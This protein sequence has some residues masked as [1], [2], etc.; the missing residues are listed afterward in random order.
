MTLK[1][2]SKITHNHS[3]FTFFLGASFN[4]SDTRSAPS[5]KSLS[6]FLLFSTFSWSSSACYF[7]SSPTTLSNSS[8]TCFILLKLFSIFSLKDSKYLSIVT[9]IFFMERGWTRDLK[10]KATYSKC[11]SSRSWRRINQFSDGPVHKQKYRCYSIG[12]NS[13]SSYAFS[14]SSGC[15]W[16]FSVFASSLNYLTCPQ[17]WQVS[18]WLLPSFFTNCHPNNLKWK[19]IRYFSVYIW[20]NPI[21]FFNR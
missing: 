1:L 20:Y 18:A 15:W 5:H 13:L 16:V 14:S 12:S 4:I 9:F 19:E 7:S 21:T 10:L 17:K 6:L 8:L 11:L 2:Y 3:P